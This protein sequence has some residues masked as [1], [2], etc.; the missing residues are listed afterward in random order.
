MELFSTV[1]VVDLSKTH[2]AVVDSSKN[3]ENEKWADDVYGNLRKYF[4]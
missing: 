3:R 4:Q 1:P 2:L